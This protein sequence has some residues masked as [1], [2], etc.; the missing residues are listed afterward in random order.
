MPSIDARSIGRNHSRRSRAA[1]STAR[2]ATLRPR[3]RCAAPTE[4]TL[5]PDEDSSHVKSSQ[6]KHDLTCCN[7][8]LT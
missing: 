7:C 8:L 2:S 1:R 4:A 6:V 5:R 3:Q